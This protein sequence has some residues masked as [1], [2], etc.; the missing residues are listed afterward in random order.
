MHFGSTELAITAFL[1]GTARRACAAGF[2][3]T[4]ASAGFSFATLGTILAHTSIIAAMVSCGH[5][6]LVFTTWALFIFTVIA[7]DF[8]AKHGCTARFT[9]F[10]A[11]MSTFKSSAAFVLVTGL[12]SAA[13]FADFC[14]P[15]CSSWATFRILRAYISVGAAVIPFGHTLF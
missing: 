13:V 7:D 12:V 8:V 14:A 6:F 4:S 9:M 2:V 5:T 15:C 10:P 1:R 3:Y 11:P